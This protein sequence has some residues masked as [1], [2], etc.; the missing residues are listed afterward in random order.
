MKFAGADAYRETQIVD[1]EQFIG[2][3]GMKAKGKRLTTYNVAT[4][5]EL[6]PLRFKPKDETNEEDTE[7]EKETEVSESNISE[8]SG[9][10]ESIEI[11]ISENTSKN[12]TENAIEESLKKETDFEDEYPEMKISRKKPIKQTPEDKNF[13]DDTTEQMS[14]F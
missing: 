13:T 10:S 4:I 2:I 8:F 11:N 3:K 6:E 9:N 12:I 5:T 1:A 7:N 14:L